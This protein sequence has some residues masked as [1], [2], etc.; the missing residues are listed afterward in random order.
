M[1]CMRDAENVQTGV[2]FFCLSDIA[3]STMFAHT[4]LKQQQQQL[5]YYRRRL[6]LHTTSY[7]HLLATE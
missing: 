2:W 7:S 1:Y 6:V 4:S 3:Y 5:R